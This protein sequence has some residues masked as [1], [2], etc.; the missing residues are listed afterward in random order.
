MATVRQLVVQKLIAMLAANSSVTKFSGA[1]IYGAHLSTIRDYVLPAVSIHILPGTG[2]EV[3]GA[4]MDNLEI[5]IE[6]W[7]AS[8]G[9]QS[10]TWDDI[11]ECHTGIMTA[12]HA[13]QGWDDSIGIKILNIQNIGKGPQIKDEDGVMHYPSR[14][15]IK[16]SL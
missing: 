7:I 6:P 14:W 9:Q 11:M 3:D 4:F 16:A 15:R 2:R 8:V 1:R 10:N 5:Q 13:Q 12:L